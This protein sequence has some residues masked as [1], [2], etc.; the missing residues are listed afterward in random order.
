VGGPAIS[1]SLVGKGM[2]E[3]VPARHWG[4]R[5][6]PAQTLFDLSRQ[7]AS[8]PCAVAEKKSVRLVLKKFDHT[9]PCDT[10][11]MIKSTTSMI[12]AL[13]GGSN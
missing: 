9:L 10:C 11:R 1:P 8:R 13:S 7:E 2:T 12:T 4:P 5:I 6:I 3:L